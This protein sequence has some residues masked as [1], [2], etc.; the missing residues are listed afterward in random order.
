MAY[1]DN[2]SCDY[3]RGHR[4]ELLADLMECERNHKKPVRKLQWEAL[5]YYPL[6]ST[7]L[8]R[9]WLK[10]KT[11]FVAADVANKRQFPE[12]FAYETFIEN[13]HRHYLLGGQRK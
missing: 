6:H 12:E 13:H 4:L 11:G 5:K 10:I 2:V 3:E 9:D 7:E 8:I 1:D